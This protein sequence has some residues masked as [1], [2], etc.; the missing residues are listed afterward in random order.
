MDKWIKVLIFIWSVLFALPYVLIQLSGYNTNATLSQKLLESKNLKENLKEET[1]DQKVDA[2]IEAEE[3]IAALAKAIPYTYEM[4]TLRAQ[5]IITRTY[6][7]RRKLNIAQ[8]GEL[9]KYSEEEMKEIWKENYDKIYDIY[10]EAVTDTKDLVIYYNDELIEP[11]YHNASGGSTRDSIDVYEV[12]IPYLKSVNSP[13]DTIIQQNEFEKEEFVS[14]LKSKYPEIIV[15]EKSIENQIQIIE[16]DKSDYIK[17]IQV[18]NVIIKGELFRQLLGL[19]SSN[20][21]VV[22]SNN[23]L[24]FVTKGIGHGVGF[25][26]NGAN[27][28]VKSGK[29]YEDILNYYFKDISIKKIEE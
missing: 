3:V 17:Q 1:A 23:K 18:G 9:K 21:K 28:M 26:Q 27:E 4:D 2:L 11:V 15:D 14:S 20:F 22:L 10:Y 19:H 13:Q 7:A 12:D 16:R 29:N 5:A 6:L 8:E 25:S 24:V